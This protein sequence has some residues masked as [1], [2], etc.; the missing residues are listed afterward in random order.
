MKNA[1]AQWEKDNKRIHFI[2]SRI[3]HLSVGFSS[4]CCAIDRRRM[5]DVKVEN[6]RMHKMRVC[7]STDEKQ[8]HFKFT[9]AH[10]YKYIYTRKWTK[11]KRPNIR[12][13]NFYAEPTEKFIYHQIIS[14]ENLNLYDYNTF[15]HW[16]VRK[17]SSEYLRYDSKSANACIHIRLLTISHQKKW[18]D[19]IRGR[20]CGLFVV[21]LFLCLHYYI[22][23]R[24]EVYAC[25]DI[26]MACKVS[27]VAQCVQNN[28]LINI[29]HFYYDCAWFLYNIFASFQVLLSNF[30]INWSSDDNKP[31]LRASTHWVSWNCFALFSFNEIIDIRTKFKFIRKK[32][33]CKLR[34][35]IN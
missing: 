23:K 8:T 27:I 16:T 25:I 19:E 11:N 32:L 30:F 12:K 2:A 26:F 15:E 22:Q 31:P 6:N 21:D 4:L 35:R 20:A 10:I 33:I 34:I 28:K 29:Q 18:T 1:F 24:S 14:D 13:T 5:V 17:S 7:V 9:R 3:G